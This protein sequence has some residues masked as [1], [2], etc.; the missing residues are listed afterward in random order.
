MK[1]FNL[2]VTNFLNISDASFNFDKNMNFIYGQPASGKSAVFE[3]MMITLSTYKR[4]STYGEYV[5]QGE[6]NATISLE[7]EI[8]GKPA[9][10]FTII[11]RVK[12][13]TCV[14]H[15]E[16][17]GET[18]ENAAVENWLKERNIDYYAKLTFAMQ[19]EEN[20]VNITSA[21]RLAYI[22]KLFNFNFKEQ[23][24][25]LKADQKE[26]E[27]QIIELNSKIAGHKATIEHLSREQVVEPRLIDDATRANYEK[28]IADK[29][30]IIELNQ[31]AMEKTNEITQQ[32]YQLNMEISSNDIKLKEAEKAKTQNQI[33]KESIEKLTIELSGLEEK[34]LLLT[35]DIIE[36]ENTIKDR[37]SARE[38]L[39]ETER[40]SADKIAEVNSSI[41]DI[42]EKIE[43]VKQGICPH[44]G[45]ETIHLDNNL[46]EKLANRESKLKAEEAY[47][48][49][50]VENLK[51]LDNQTKADN[52]SLS[53][54]R[55]E[56][57]KASSDKSHIEKS[58]ETFKTRIELNP[59]YDVEA[60]TK[61]LENL[62]AKKAELTRD[63]EQYKVEKSTK[64]ILV[65]IEPLKKAI[66]D[67]T[68]I[69]EK[70]ALI[71]KTNSENKAK[72]AQLLI[73]NE[74]L[75][76]TVMTLNNK[77]STIKEAYDILNKSLPQ[78]IS[79]SICDRLEHKINSFIHKIFPKF[80]VILET[81]DKGCDLKYTKDKTIIDEKRNKYLKANMA[82]GL[83]KS[84]LN[85]AFKVSLAE[86][87][88]LDLFVGDEIDE[89]SNDKDAKILIDVLINSKSF[90][91][92]FIISHKNAVLE[93]ITEN[94]KGNVYHVEEGK[95][96]KTIF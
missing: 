48:A 94:Y 60:I 1:V 72:C 61:E 39:S 59:N 64:D 50:V 68:I 86:A 26:V 46:D 82:S 3:A 30:K 57:S 29:M 74:K 81:T 35:K 96:S 75:L 17:D 70:N 37:S 56:L 31:A 4:S 8:L 83:E 71:M 19:N 41:K 89:S 53:N 45:Q 52:D 43:L 12:G 88:N 36:K 47:R 66:N 34:I 25:K 23:K 11:N 21:E 7:A 6:D 93:H 15:L 24:D 55:M 54:M 95:F 69:I 22:Q 92:L 67:D 49:E 27:A 16:Y 5:K 14:R 87:Y 40:E 63:L 38:Q 77:I 10:F 76:D 13:T 42:K 80:Q 18:Y 9:K 79:K 2:H 73:E 51:N 33:D 44:C 20:I 91:Q 84:L 62:N 85:L 65:E 58:I 28:I 78:Y 32:I 90:E